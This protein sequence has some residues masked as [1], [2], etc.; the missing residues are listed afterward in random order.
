MAKVNTLPHAVRDSYREAFFARLDT[1]CAIAD[2]RPV[3][4]LKLE[5]RS[6]VGLVEC[7]SCHSPFMPA[8]GTEDVKLELLGSASPKDR[9]QAIDV[10]GK[11]GL[12]ALREVSTES[13]R[14]KVGQTI[15]VIRS[16]LPP[17]DAVR[18]VN[19][20]RPIWTA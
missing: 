2:G 10:M 4:V 14:A 16:L 1:L 5:L 7:P 17:D 9:V 20:L 8:E 12:G 18:I 13:V 11:Y 3:Q 15:D 6:L 19:A